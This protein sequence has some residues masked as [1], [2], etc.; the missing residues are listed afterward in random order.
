MLWSIKT[1]SELDYCSLIFHRLVGNLLA[2]ADE[3]GRCF[4]HHCRRRASPDLIKLEV[5]INKLTSTLK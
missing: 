2:A 5:D 4:G 3:N 1:K